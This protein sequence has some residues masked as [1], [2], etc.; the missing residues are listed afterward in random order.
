MSYKIEGKQLHSEV[1]I[2]QDIEEVDEKLNISPVV[3]DGSNHKALPN[4][5]AK[6]VFKPSTKK[7]I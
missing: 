5:G 7:K 3:S 2:V 6:M 1:D 4:M